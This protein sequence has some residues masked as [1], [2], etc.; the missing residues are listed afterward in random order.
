M[1]NV[2]RIILSPTQPDFNHGWLKPT[3]SGYEL[4]FFRPEIGRW[5]LVSGK[6]SSSPSEDYN[7]YTDL[8]TVSA[9]STEVQVSLPDGYDAATNILILADPTKITAPSFTTT[10]VSGG[11]TYL[12]GTEQEVTVSVSFEAGSDL[13]TFK[14]LKVNG[15][16]KTWTNPEDGT[17]YTYTANVSADTSVY[18]TLT[19]EYRDTGTYTLTNSSKKTSLKFGLPLYYGAYLTSD[20][21][22]EFTADWITSKLNAT[23]YQQSY[24]LAEASY[25]YTTTTANKWT[26]I[27]AV[28]NSF[29]LSASKIDMYNGIY[30]TSTKNEVF[31]TQIGTATIN[32]YLYDI[33]QDTYSYIAPFNYRINK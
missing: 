2:D 14:S 26:A 1:K 18:F 9:G 23:S 10:T 21:P 28:P 17:V 30:W 7:V 6:G 25:G 4:Y 29:G 12:L 31:A 19:Y 8:L 15:L 22:D 20:K 24:V 32:G 11:G 3:D 16:N 27:W 33:F 5:V 13:W